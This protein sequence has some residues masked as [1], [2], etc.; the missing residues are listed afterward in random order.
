MTSFCVGDGVR[1][2]GQRRFLKTADPM[3]MLRPPDLVQPGEEGRVVELRAG[4]QLAVRF[5][6]GTFLLAAADLSPLDDGPP[7]GAAP[8]PDPPGSGKAG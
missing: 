5:R 7:P 3:P 6:R 4:D 2:R 8:Q 1:L